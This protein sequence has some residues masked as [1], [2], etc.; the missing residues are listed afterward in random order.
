MLNAKDGVT[1]DEQKEA[2]RFYGSAENGVVGALEA[3]GVDEVARA[4]AR[5][6]V[7]VH[8]LSYSAA[9]GALSEATAAVEIS[10]DAS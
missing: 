2:C 7:I 10:A 1:I 6:A 4:S 9:R 5:Q 8:F 3:R